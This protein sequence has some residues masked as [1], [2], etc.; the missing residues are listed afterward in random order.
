MES[1]FGEPFVIFASWFLTF[2]YELANYKDS[3]CLSSLQ[4]ALVSAMAS[5]INGMLTPYRTNWDQKPSIA[6][7]QA[8]LQA[9]A[10]GYVARLLPQ[11]HPIPP[12]LKEILS[13]AF[14]PTELE[15]GNVG[16]GIKQLPETQ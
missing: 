10:E 4:L 1:V 11:M 5:Q 14:S 3:I 13:Q 15:P 16:S 8:H 6:R 2:A 7:D 9:Q 12:R